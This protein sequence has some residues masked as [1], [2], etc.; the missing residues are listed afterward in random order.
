M[1]K[2]DKYTKGTTQ[3]VIRMDAAGFPLESVE[4][5][6]DGVLWHVNEGKAPVVLRDDDEVRAVVAESESRGG[7]GNSPE[8]GGGGGS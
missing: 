1:A 2:G 5:D 4:R 8:H 3:Q 6:T 7:G